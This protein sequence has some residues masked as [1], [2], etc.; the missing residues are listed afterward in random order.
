MLNTVK[1]L[2]SATVKLM[3]ALRFRPAWLGDVEL[4]LPEGALT[5]SLSKRLNRFAPVVLKSLNYGISGFHR[6]VAW[7]FGSSGLLHI[8]FR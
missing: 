5:N 7:R 4:L 6:G 8:V 3:Y 1:F 2:D